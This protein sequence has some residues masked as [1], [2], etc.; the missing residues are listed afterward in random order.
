MARQIDSKFCKKQTRMEHVV[1]VALVD[2]KNA[3]L[4]VH[5]LG[6]DGGQDLVETLELQMV[7]HGALDA[8]DESLSAQRRGS[9]KS[10]LGLLNIIDGLSLFGFVSNSLVK[11]IIVLDARKA[12]FALPK[13]A[14]VEAVLKEIY[15]AYVKKISNPFVEVEAVLVPSYGGKQAKYPD[16]LRGFENEIDRVLI[17]H[18]NLRKL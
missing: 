12:N 3:P 9:R 11:I 5:R 1:A 17:E 7:V 8:F 16:L 18:Q 4:L 10:Y 15:A 2:A 6:G 13:D 14:V